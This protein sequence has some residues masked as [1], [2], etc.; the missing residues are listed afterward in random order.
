MCEICLEEDDDQPHIMRCKPVNSKLKSQD[1]TRGLAKYE[2]IYGDPHKQKVISVLFKQLL[3]IRKTMVE[4]N[5]QNTL[6]PSIS[7]E[8][9]KT[10]Y[11]LQPCIVNYSSGT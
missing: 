7:A 4:D 2:D 8:M 5:R 6:D 1:V 10:S 9:L 3:D 11:D